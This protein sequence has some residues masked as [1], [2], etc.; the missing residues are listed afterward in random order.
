MNTKASTNDV[1]PFKR[2]STGSLSYV[3][4]FTDSSRPRRSQSYRS[5]NHCTI[6]WIEARNLTKELTQDTFIPWFQPGMDSAPQTSYTDEMLPDSDF[7]AAA[8]PGYRYE[9]RGMNSHGGNSFHPGGCQGAK[10]GQEDCHQSSQLDH[11][12]LLHIP[13]SEDDD[14][15][16]SGK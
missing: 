9:A 4:G 13:D 14:D 5:L 15:N 7:A 1:L 2:R 8:F 11:M 16:D 3:Q 12:K 6:T 10:S